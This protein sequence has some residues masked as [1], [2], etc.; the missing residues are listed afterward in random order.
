MLP[1]FP[2]RQGALVIRDTRTEGPMFQRVFESRDLGEAVIIRGLPR[3]AG[4][5]PRE[6]HPP[7]LGPVTPIR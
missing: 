3:A 5:R 1:G 2:G 6:T 7:P 4:F